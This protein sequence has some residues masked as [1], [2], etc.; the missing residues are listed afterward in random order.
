M[1][2]HSAV[3]ITAA[4]LLIPLAH[5]G[6]SASNRLMVTDALDR[7]VGFAQPPQRIAVAGKATFMV[8]NAACL[9]PQARQRI[10]PFFAGGI[11]R[12]G[13]GDF[14]SQW[15]LNQKATAP[16]DGNAS[17]EQIASTHPDVVLLKSASRRLGDTL[18]RIGIPVVYLDFETPVQYERDLTVFGQL[19]D[20]PARAKELIS[21]YQKIQEAVQNRTETLRAADKPRVLLIQYSE[22]AGVIAFSVPSRGWIQTEMVERAGGIPVW[23]DAAQ[24]GGWTIVNLEQIAAW[25][26]D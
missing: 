9:F 19:L 15:I 21:Y 13:A 23:K 2:I 12:Q 4:G 5:T 25:H 7:V 17:V 11:S 16:F 6:Y 8:A 22:R 1:N 3:M 24:Q 26:P 20:A 10:L 14:L 18:D